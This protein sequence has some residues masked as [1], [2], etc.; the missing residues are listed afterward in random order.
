M[1]VAAKPIA[2]R[3]VMPSAISQIAQAAT[4]DIAWR[5]RQSWAAA[6]GSTIARQSMVSPTAASSAAASAVCP[7]EAAKRV[8]TVSPTMV[9]PTA[10]S[11]RTR[12]RKIWP[13]LRRTVTLSNTAP[14]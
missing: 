6:L 2:A 11:P 9:R 13:L 5:S 4:A 12:P 7:N 10:T 1:L 14:G 8:L 3:S